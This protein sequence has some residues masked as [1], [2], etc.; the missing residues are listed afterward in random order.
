[1]STILAWILTIQ[2]HIIFRRAF[3]TVEVLIKFFCRKYYCLPIAILWSLYWHGY[4]FLKVKLNR[5]YIFVII[6]QIRYKY[7]NTHN[8]LYTW[9]FFQGVEMDIKTCITSLFSTLFG[10]MRIDRYYWE[11]KHYD[12]TSFRLLV[13][14]FSYQYKVLKKCIHLFS[15]GKVDGRKKIVTVTFAIIQFNFVHISSFSIIFNVHISHVIY[16]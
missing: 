14:L 15:W 8:V 16:L 9:Q 3:L 13:I 5:V 2:L 7:T 6:I 4:S 12:A 10:F 11:K 1:M